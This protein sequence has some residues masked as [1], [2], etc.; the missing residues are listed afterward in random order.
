[1]EPPRYWHCCPGGRGGV[2]GAGARSWRRRKVARALWAEAVEVGVWG[3]AE[4]CVG[5]VGAAGEGAM[6]VE[7]QWEGREEVG[8]CW[9]GVLRTGRSF[10]CRGR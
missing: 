7:G 5:E 1:M 3:E 6:Q 9:I 4:W 10:A 8:G 2:G